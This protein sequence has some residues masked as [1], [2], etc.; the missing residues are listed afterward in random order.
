[1]PAG[2]VCGTSRQRG[3]SWEVGQLQVCGGVWSSVV[4]AAG[5]PLPM[6]PLN[7]PLWSCQRILT[8]SVLSEGVLWPQEQAQYV[9]GHP[10]GPESRMTNLCQ[11]AQDT[12]GFSTGSPRA[13]KTPQSQADCDDWSPCG[14]DT[15][16]EQSSS[17]DGQVWVYKP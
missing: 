17:K 3:G 15:S 1:M 7:L 11:F 9:S 16:Q 4:D 8:C 2:S 6:S 12:P 14:G 10:G 13:Q 5:C